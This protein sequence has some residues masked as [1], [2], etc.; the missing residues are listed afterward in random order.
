[1]AEKREAMTN[2]QLTDM[3]TNNEKQIARLVKI[4]EALQGDVMGLERRMETLEGRGK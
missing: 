1:M 3:V 2:E 4:V